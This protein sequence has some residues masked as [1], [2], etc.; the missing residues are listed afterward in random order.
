M[1]KIYSLVLFL[2]LFGVAAVQEAGAT[3]GNASVSVTATVSSSCVIT[4]PP[5]LDFGTLTLDA[6]GNAPSV[7]RSIAVSFWCTQGSTVSLGAVTGG[8]T[9]L[10][11]DGVGTSKQI[12]YATAAPTFTGRQLASGGGGPSAPFSMNVSATIANGAYTGA[13][14][15]SYTDTI[16]VPINY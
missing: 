12:A 4:A 6:E 3:T 2:A 8:N 10:T 15:G 16:V 9:L 1:K 14:A 7:N 11:G 13:M 5:T